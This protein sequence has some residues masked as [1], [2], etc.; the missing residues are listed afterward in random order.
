M[1]RQ[2]VLSFALLLLKV[3][4]GIFE[5]RF[6]NMH[7]TANYS[8]QWSLWCTCLHSDDAAC[9][10]VSSSGTYA[11]ISQL[12]RNANIV[13][14]ACLANEVSRAWA[15]FV[16]KFHTA[17]CIGDTHISNSWWHITPREVWAQKVF[18]AWWAP[19]ELFMRTS[20]VLPWSPIFFVCR[21][22]RW[23]CTY[24]WLLFL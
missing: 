10:S 14:I 15:G 9:I 17:G 20:L 22:A 4:H 24:Q 3:L 2:I 7:L 8:L 18:S 12:A 6:S 11:I 19:S 23:R 21:N 1:G 5:H 16:S 13:C